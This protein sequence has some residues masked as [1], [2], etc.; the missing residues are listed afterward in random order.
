MIPRE[1]WIS[2][3]QTSAFTWA[4]VAFLFG[5][6]MCVHSRAFQEEERLF[7]ELEHAKAYLKRL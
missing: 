7:P 2:D 3:I 1:P 5:S 6:L 4:G